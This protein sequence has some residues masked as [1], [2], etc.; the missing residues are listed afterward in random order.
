VGEW[1]TAA[2]TATGM[3]VKGTAMM[4]TEKAKAMFAVVA[5]AARCS[6]ALAALAGLLLLA[7][8]ANAEAYDPAAVLT[9]SVKVA[10]ALPTDVTRLALTVAAASI[11]VNGLCFG[12][13][14]WLLKQGLQ[15]PCM[16]Q[17]AP[18]QAVMR[19]ELR[20]AR[21]EGRRA[22]LIEAKQRAD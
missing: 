21:E 6:A 12:T 13:F 14:I 15:K 16:M 4:S 10:E 18:G 11:I 9:T 3:W 19:D 2:G 17:S 1:E 5:E 22:A 20:Q 7:V 8:A